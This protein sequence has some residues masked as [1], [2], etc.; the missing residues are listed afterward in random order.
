[1]RL[2]LAQK[3]LGCWW[4]FYA[5]AWS[6]H[7][8]NRIRGI[9]FSWRYFA[10]INRPALE[11]GLHKALNPSRGVVLSGTWQSSEVAGSPAKR[12]ELGGLR[13]RTS[14]ANRPASPSLLLGHAPGRGAGLTDVQERP[15][16]EG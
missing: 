9:R 11:S 1:M 16:C 8:E 2:K 4:V 5:A 6:D 12:R 3:G 7:H 13:T 14:A 15:A 10:M